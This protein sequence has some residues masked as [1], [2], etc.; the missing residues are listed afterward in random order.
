MLR[1]QGDS[2]AIKPDTAL[3]QALVDFF[4]VLEPIYAGGDHGVFRAI[5]FGGCAVHIHTKARGSADV[6]VEITSHGQADRSEIIALLGED[7]YSFTSDEGLSQILELDK[8]FST[9]LGPLHEDYEDR[10][11]LLTTQSSSP[12]VEVYVASP[13]D[14]AISK[15]GRF[16]KRDQDDIQSLLNLPGV[17]IEEFER[18]AKEAI[19]YYVGNPVPVLGNLRNTIQDYHQGKES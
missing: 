5:V 6:D 13:I 12:F 1:E 10:A 15:L 7:A 17:S 3:G 18:L 11:I 2:Q 16:G 8:S 4:E 19:G 9:T 14:V